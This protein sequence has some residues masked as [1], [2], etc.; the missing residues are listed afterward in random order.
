MRKILFILSLFI[1]F[2]A[3]GQNPIQRANA[4]FTAVDTYLRASKSFGTAIYSDTA[5]Y[6]GLDSL[7]VIIY[8]KLQGL[9]LRDTIDGVGHKWSRLVTLAEN[10]TLNGTDLYAS[11]T[12]YD[13]GIGTTNP[14]YKFHVVNGNGNLG[15]DASGR[16]I[17][18]NSLSNHN[19]AI[20]ESAT[21]VLTNKEYNIS[22][23]YAAN[24]FSSGD[25]NIAIGA[26]SLLS[27]SGQNNVAIG[28]NS[29]YATDSSDNSGFGYNSGIGNYGKQN[30]SI[31]SGSGNFATELQTSALS[32]T[33][34]VTSSS[35]LSGAEIATFIT[36]AGLSVGV[37][38]VFN[39]TFAG[40]PPSPYTVTGGFTSQG[41]V[42]S[43]NTLSFPTQAVFTTQGSGGFTLTVYNKQDNAIAI[44]YMA[45]TD[46]SNQIA[47]G[48]SS[49]SILKANQFIVDLMDVPATG[50]VL[51]WDG[52]KAI[53]DTI[54][55]GGGGAYS[56]LS[57][58]S[59]AAGVVSIANAAANGSTKGAASFTAADFN[60][61]SGNISIDYTNGQ[62]ATT[63]LKGF[64][65]STDWN[66]FNNKIS[67]IT[68]LVTAGTNIS[69]TGSG[70]SGSPYVI[71]TS[72]LAS[73]ITSLNGLTAATQIFAIGSTGTAPSWSVSGGNTHSLNLPT[74]S[75]S[76]TGL[77]TPT[78]YNSWTAKQ[79]AITG[80]AT[81]ILTSNLTSNRA[82][83]SNGS[84]KIDISAVTSTE[85]GYLSGATS[86]IQTQINTITDK[87]FNTLTDGA[88]V[89]Y[90]YSLGFNAQLT[91]GGNRNISITNMS[92][93]DYATIFIT[94]DATGGRDITFTA[95]TFL[96]D[97][98]GTGTTVDLTDTPNALDILTIVKRGSVLYVTSGYFH[99]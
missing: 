56:F 31:G 61:S 21:G 90:D 78:L 17:L 29:L 88:I 53:W 13:V 72:G 42:T 85:L 15:F 98:I 55:G 97:G 18:Y 91:I 10:W 50:E 23:G 52:T 22:I 62:S 7:G 64:L 92:E 35:T 30:V 94:Q 66:T 2:V 96:L 70:T 86:N 74:T 57:P 6:S 24:Q 83:I 34:V 54:T 4:T 9:Y 5:D 39:V 51:T 20:G 44:G 87:A 16:L 76:N 84:G 8:V 63:T 45:R 77:V 36:N 33:N 99:N 68:G 32:N 28:V 65:T 93:G 19:I 43:S 67:N 60:A 40:T 26:A 82:V 41:T 14:S 11:S 25:R 79:D 69:I 49:N 12:T 89:T 71:S 3:E 81:T 37:K 48:N 80:A 46:S 27:A 95:G 73:G 1:C 38:Y 75:A 47:L 58:L 59:E